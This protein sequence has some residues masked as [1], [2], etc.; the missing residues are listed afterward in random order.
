MPSW[1]DQPANSQYKR[2]LRALGAATPHWW[3]GEMI[4]EVVGGDLGSGAVISHLPVSGATYL[5][6]LPKDQ[7]PPE[8][9]AATLAEIQSGHFQHEW[10]DGEWRWILLTREVLTA[11][12]LERIKSSF[13]S[14][15]SMG[16][17]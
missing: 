13:W 2:Q 5:A 17:Q 14:S 8:G 3:P 1:L 10:T 12:D 7:D 15:K 16:N 9:V 6:R 11:E 4:V